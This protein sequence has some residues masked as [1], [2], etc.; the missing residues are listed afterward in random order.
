MPPSVCARS[1]RKPGYMP[2]P[3][4]LGINTDAYQPIERRYGITRAVLEVL[5]ETQA[6]GQL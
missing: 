3:I 5:A 4:A 1:S 2:Q 6:S